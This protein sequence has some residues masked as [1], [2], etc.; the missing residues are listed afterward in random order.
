MNSF[1]LRRCDPSALIHSNEYVEFLVNPL[2]CKPLLDGIWVAYETPAFD[3]N[4]T[5]DQILL[6]HVKRAGLL[7]SANKS[8]RLFVA[9]WT[10]EVPDLKVTTII[11]KPFMMAARTD[12]AAHFLVVLM[13]TAL[14]C[15]TD[16][17]QGFLPSAVMAAVRARARLP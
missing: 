12:A 14:T 4:D 13:Q 1:I 7:Q 5:G 3:C 11:A 2:D 16:D 10:C 8:A 9:H 15:K 17:Q 6:G